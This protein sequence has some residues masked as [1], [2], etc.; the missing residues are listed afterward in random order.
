MLLPE[1]ELFDPEEELPELPELPDPLDELEDEPAERGFGAG[2]GAGDATGSIVPTPVSEWIPRTGCSEAVGAGRATD[3]PAGCAPS[4]AG[5]AALSDAGA[6]APPATEV[7]PTEIPARAC[8]ASSIEGSTARPIT[9]SATTTMIP[10]VRRIF[11]SSMFAAA[12]EV[13]VKAR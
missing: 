6:S 10:R 2:A 7:S 5:C 4:L 9:A 11:M 3:F 13:L 8:G 12:D 1:E